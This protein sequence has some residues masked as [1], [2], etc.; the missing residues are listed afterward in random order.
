MPSKTDWMRTK[1]EQDPN[2]VLRPYEGYHWEG[3]YSNFR[4]VP[5]SGQGFENSYWVQRS[6]LRT[7][8]MISAACNGSSFHRQVR[9]QHGLLPLLVSMVGLGRK[10]VRVLDFGG[11]MGVSYFHV[12]QALP[13][14]DFVDYTIVET[15]PVCKS[16]RELFP[17]DSRVYFVDEL[18]APGVRFDIVYLNSSLQYIEDYSGLLNH[19]AIYDPSYF[20]FVRLSAGAQPTYATAQMNVHGSQIP[21]WFVSL[22]EIVSIMSSLGYVLVFKSTSEDELNQENFPPSHRIGQPCNV[23]FRKLSGDSAAPEGAL[24]CK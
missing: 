4:E 5:R 24:L 1:N 10:K 7:E 13:S 21:Y 8:A 16:A 18:P 23:L 6:R 15:A 19:L 11:G 9:G 22:S 2:D 20:L 14:A 17:D 3:I 12:S